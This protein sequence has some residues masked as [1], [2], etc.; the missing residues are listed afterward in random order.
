V[1]LPVLNELW[2]EA[3]APTDEVPRRVLPLL[4]AAHLGMGRP[5]DARRFVDAYLAR[6]PVPAAAAAELVELAARVSPEIGDRVAGAVGAAQTSAARTG[7][8]QSGAAQTGA[9]A[10][11]GS[12]PGAARS[13]IRRARSVV[14][15]LRS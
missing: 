8:A 1:Y 6:G 14:G 9:T 15:R 10:P 5:D 11:H 4:A 13:P 2:P 3:T 7:A 12:V